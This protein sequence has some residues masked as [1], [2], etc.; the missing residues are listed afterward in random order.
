[1]LKRTAL[2]ALSLIVAT[3][4]AAHPGGHSHMSLLELVQHYAEPDHL[5]FLVLAVIVGWLAYALGRRVE[6][7]VRA[8]QTRKDRT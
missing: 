4:A 8:R 6:A 2:L 1:M 3:P 7:R 5:A